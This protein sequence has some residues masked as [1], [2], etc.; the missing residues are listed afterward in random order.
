MQGCVIL[1]EPLVHRTDDPEAR[2]QGSIAVGLVP[3]QLQQRL[4]A[5]P[6]LL[7]AVREEVV[8]LHLNQVPAVLG[9]HMLRVVDDERD[10]VGHKRHVQVLLGGGRAVIHGDDTCKELLLR[11]K[12]LPDGCRVVPI[13]HGVDVQ[14]KQLPGRIQELV[15]VGPQLGPQV[16]HLQVV[17]QLV[18]QG[19]LLLQDGVQLRRLL[20]VHLWHVHTVEQ[21]V[22]QVQHQNQ[23]PRPEQPLHVQLTQ[24]LRFTSTNLKVTPSVQ[25]LHTCHLCL[26]LLLLPGV[27]CTWLPHAGGGVG[28]GGLPHHLL[29]I[30]VHVRLRIRVPMRL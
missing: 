30:C 4:L 16:A 14:L 27:L 11:V 13:T 8:P 17:Q 10:V 9:P 29:G 22:V 21:G 25:V 28:C 23:L 18:G 24:S 12:D 2:G 7:G 3:A 5:G 15:H 19:S 20:G 26:L 1:K 6:E